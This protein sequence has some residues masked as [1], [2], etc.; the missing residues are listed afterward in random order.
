MSYIK[1]KTFIEVFPTSTDFVS[2]F[3]ESVY[4]EYITDTSKLEIIYDL[5]LSKYENSRIS[6]INVT[7]WKRQVNS[8]LFSYGPTFIKKLEIQKTL[9][10]LTEKDITTGAVNKNTHGYN[11]S[12]VPG[13]SNSDTEIETVN[14]QSLQKYTKG[15]LD[16]YANLWEL[17]ANDIT[18]SFIGKFKKLFMSVIDI[19]DVL[20]R[21][22][23]EI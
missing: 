7:S 12:D 2:N 11:P 10:E 23:E 18:S 19:D 8:I 1:T 15:K 9:R 20:S 4:K 6:S 13:T 22:E 16:G 14:E 21:L 3:T 5:L 17:L